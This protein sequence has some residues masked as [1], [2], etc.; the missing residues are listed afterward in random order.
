MRIVSRDT[1]IRFK[2]KMCGSCCRRL[3]NLEITAYDIVN[4][5]ELGRKDIIAHLVAIQDDVARS[6]GVPFIFTFP[7]RGDGSCIYLRGNICTIHEIKPLACRIYPFGLGPNYELIIQEECR[8]LGEGDPVNIDEVI[9]LI[10]KHLAGIEALKI[11]KVKDEILRIV[12]EAKNEILRKI[13]CLEIFEKV[14]EGKPDY[15]KKYAFMD[16]GK[17][18]YALYYGDLGEFTLR[19]NDI[20]ALARWFAENARNLNE[21]VT[22]I[23]IHTRE[24]EE[25]ENEK[26]RGIVLMYCTSRPLM[27]VIDVHKRCME[28]LNDLGLELTTVFLRY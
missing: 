17:Y 2:C 3:L 19:I 25:S 9:K 4:W 14:E 26:C 24:A 16:L 1:V 28:L 12:I 13:G 20:D 23:H 15:V 11:P 21:A 27:S 10:R 6:Y 18:I 22:V 5:W 8:G 7:R